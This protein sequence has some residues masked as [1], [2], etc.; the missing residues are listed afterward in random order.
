MGKYCYIF[1]A[2]WNILL[3]FGI[4]YDHLEHFV[5]IWY[6]FP[7]LVSCTK[8][9]LATLQ[10]DMAFCFMY[11]G[12]FTPTIKQ[13]EGVYII[14]PREHSSPLG[15]KFTPMGKLHPRGQK[16]LL[17]TGLCHKKFSHAREC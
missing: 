4:F 8:E 6:I 2:I 14:P 3:T 1:L 17:K 5:V 9:N 13:L 11:V 15:A 12:T 10:P 7:V 16:M